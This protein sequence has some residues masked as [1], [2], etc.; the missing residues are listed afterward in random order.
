VDDKLKQEAVGTALS[1]GAPLRSIQRQAT[2]VATAQE[3]DK[4]EGR[5]VPRLGFSSSEH[6]WRVIALLEGSGIE[7]RAGKLGARN[8][9]PMKFRHGFPKCESGW[10]RYA[11]VH[12]MNLPPIVRER[13]VNSISNVKPIPSKYQGD[14][15]MKKSKWALL[16]VAAAAGG[17]M[18]QSSVTV[19]GKIDV[20][21]VLD[22]GSPAGKS[23]RISSGVTGGSRLGF[24]GTEDLGGGNKASF[25][26]ETGFCAD[27]TAGAPNFCTGSN[28]FMGRQAFGAL[29]GS[30]GILSAGRQY[31]IGFNHLATIDPFGG[32]W[33]GNSINADGAGNYLVDASGVRL[34]NS[35]TYTTPVFAHV[36]VSGEM[37]LGETT[38]N[39]AAGRETGAA[40]IYASGPM[41]AGLSWYALRN[42]TGSG[43]ARDNVLAGATYDFGVIKLHGAIQKVAGHPSAGASMNLLNVL[44]GATVPVAGGYAIADYIRHD[45]RTSADRDANQWAAGYQYLLSKRTSLYAAYARIE[46]R[47]GANFHV[48]NATDLGTG[49]K[50]FDLGV[51]HNF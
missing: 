30:W 5:E 41:Y 27:S 47:D 46:N 21:L 38:G 7:H 22:S 12:L 3:E 36:T 35:A 25:Q 10:A 20:G 13:G 50:G 26:I 32:G 17:A 16:G 34:N 6:S 4:P 9:R 37:S 11:G 44:V 23:V 40:A 28:N 19:Y 18:A 43:V 8:V 45:D 39:W 2:V 33:A 42:A 31:S 29:S 14:R 15:V 51:V 49:N 1:I 48:G 24:K